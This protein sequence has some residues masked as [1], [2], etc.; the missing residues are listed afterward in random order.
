LDWED[1]KRK[2]R[3]PTKKTKMK[4]IIYENDAL[5]WKERI[6]QSFLFFTISLIKFEGQFLHQTPFIVVAEIIL[7][8]L[9]LLSSLLIENKYSLNFF[10]AIRLS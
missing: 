8:V 5:E 9:L 3:L 4:Q 6:L 10:L 2:R 7:L 1:G